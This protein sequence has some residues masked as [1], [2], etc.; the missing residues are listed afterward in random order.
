MKPTAYFINTARGGIH[1]EVALAEALE[2]GKLA[3]AGLDVW[4]NEPP[5]LAHPLLA[6]DNVIASPHTAGVTHE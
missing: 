6:M 5:D 1:D 3:G 2:N 4:E